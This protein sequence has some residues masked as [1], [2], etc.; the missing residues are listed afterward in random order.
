MLGLEREFGGLGFGHGRPG[1]Q[2]VEDIELEI[3]AE[4][5]LD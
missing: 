2:L 3:A 5:F 4:R 1:P